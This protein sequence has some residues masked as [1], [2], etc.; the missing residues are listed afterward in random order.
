[1]NHYTNGNAPPDSTTI[2][3]TLHTMLAP[4]QVVEL[5]ILDVEGNSKQI[6]SGY[7][8][9]PALLAAAAAR[10]SG[11]G[12]VYI[13]PNVVDPALLA[14]AANNVKKWARQTTND[15]QVT[16]RRWLLI[17]ADPE[18]PS[19]ISATDAEH[20]AALARVVELGI[21]LAGCGWPEPVIASSGNGGHANYAIDLPNTEDSTLLIQRCLLALSMKFTDE[22]VKID[23]S[24][25]NA[26]R[27][28]KLYGTKAVKGDSTADRPHRYA[29]IL[30]KPEVLAP[31]KI[32]QLQALASLAPDPSAKKQVSTKG[33]GGTF[34][35][36][37]W[38]EKHSIAGHKKEWNGGYRW[39]L[40][41][42]PFSTAHT[43]GAF[44]VQLANGAIAAGCKHNTCQGKDWH[45]LRALFDG[46]KEERGAK[47][48]QRTATG[49][50]EQQSAPDEA[51]ENGAFPYAVQDN[52][53]GEWKTYIN[54]NT[55][56]KVDIFEPICN[57]NAWI[58][59]DVATDDGEETERKIA[60]AGQ[61]SSGEPLPEI[62]I[63]ASEF[64]TMKWPVAQWGARIRIKPFRGATN[65]LRYAIQLL[66]TG[67]MSDR[68][69][70]THTGWTVIEGK[71]VFLHAGG[72][73]GTDA[74]SVDLPRNL[75][76]YNFPTDNAVD[77]VF[78]MK[79]SIKFLDIAPMRV[80]APLWA[81]MYLAPLSEFIPA[82]FTLSIEGGSGDLKSSFSAV[83]L[84][85]YGQKFTEYA[86]PADWLA[87]ANSLEK[88]CFHAKDVPL[89][90]DDLRPST[91]PTE[92]RMLQEAVS[93]IT[94]AAGNRQGRGRLDANSQFKRT[95]APRGVVIMTAERKAMGKSTNSRILTV[96]VDP[97]D[98]NAGLL[99][100]AQKQRHV[101]AYAMRGYIESIAKDWE[102]LS[103]A[104][105]A[106]VV[107]LR[108]ANGGEG[109]HRRLPNATAI[110]HTAFCCAMS[111]AI[112]IGAID[113][114][115]AE[116]REQECYKVLKDM[117][118]S[119][120]QA[121]EAEDPARKYITIIASLIAQE[122][123]YLSG[124]GA[125]SVIGNEESE[126]LGW[127]DGQTV[128]LLP[129]AYNTVCKFASAEGW[130]FPSDEGTLRKE[131]ERGGY[132]SR[133]AQ[134]RLTTTMRIPGGGGV[135]RVTAIKFAALQGTLA[136]M[137]YVVA[138]SVTT[139]GDE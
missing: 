91:N 14:R 113:Q 50:M 117:A 133:N 88:L 29:E 46:T 115:D 122:K 85:H 12:Q 76:N 1:M 131:L 94:R 77:P 132:M 10:Y 69:T 104:L 73:I 99:S 48:A 61:L 36:E 114:A 127:H 108:A 30:S 58:V 82:V 72:A 39:K 66:S 15:L 87:T 31:V 106:Q 136:D 63:E 56:E 19:G 84:N 60:I 103:V 42:C 137:G 52:Q 22:A 130:N 118:E 102:E 23:T 92:S 28:W 20:A 123:A 16:R 112:E 121:T 3:D 57:F 126:K 38:M 134:E 47:K 110:L 5:R 24:V 68:R 6:D 40:D 33:K 98:I 120:N 44:I 35:L 129:G 7:F 83:G 9:N 138:S 32:E 62:L 2:L 128:Y 109:H 101:Y 55:G 119:Q 65:I 34:D 95:F 86:M 139:E 17:D 25:Y 124:K 75:S 93:R 81:A 43:D 107:E 64:E 67:K 54:R 45:D 18:R 13:T 105:P 21:F 80:S 90:I 79:E 70:L 41:A 49:T 116:R 111:Y 135:V 78:A 53:I 4:G 125:E 89:V 8:D 97:G 37:A 96:D 27:I 74:V 51:P 11:H 26:A 100:V 59:A 71:H